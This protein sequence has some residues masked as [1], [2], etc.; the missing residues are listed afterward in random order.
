MPKAQIE[1]WLARQGMHPPFQT[2]QLGGGDINRAYR[3][4]D[5]LGS[6]VFVKFHPSAPDAHFRAETQGLG[7][8]S[9]AAGR[10]S[11]PQQP[12]F[13]V[14]KVIG[15]STIAGG[16]VFL[17]LEYL[18]FQSPRVGHWFQAGSALAL[19]Q[20]LDMDH[21]LGP[22]VYGLDQDNMI[23]STP[24][25]NNPGQSWAEFFAERRLAFQLELAMRHQLLDK[26]TQ[27]GIERLVKLIGDFL[28]ENP[29]ACLLHGDLWRGNIA[30][31]SR[32]PVYIDPAVYLGHAEADL[33]MT[34]L[35]GAFP[36]EFYQ[37]YQ[38]VAGPLEPGYE[39]RRL[40]YNLYHLLNH[41][42]LFGSSYLGSVTESLRRLGF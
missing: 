1:D 42:N 20:G 30:F 35:F 41:L 21:L 36:A 39:Q 22:G 23:G 24:Q 7:L 14:P 16:G 9:D 37:G 18:E 29:K 10:L 33:A 13:R 25:S 31:D 26:R 32:G 15:R 2:Q 6:P 38:E 17:V 28:P 19:L 8:L 27:A 11:S 12:A 3:Y 5:S 4:E 34:E 40:V